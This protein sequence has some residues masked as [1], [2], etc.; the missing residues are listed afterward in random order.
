MKAMRQ[1]HCPDLTYS[2]M[3]KV[4]CFQGKTQLKGLFFIYTNSFSLHF[5]KPKSSCDDSVA[6]GQE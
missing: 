2:K 4:L 1:Q 5:H 6:K 3:R